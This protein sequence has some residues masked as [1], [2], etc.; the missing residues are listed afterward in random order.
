[1]GISTEQWRS[2]IGTF[3]L[4]KCKQTDQREPVTLI[5]E[6][7]ANINSHIPKGP[8]KLYMAIIIISTCMIL[9]PSYLTP[10]HTES[11]SKA[12]YQAPS[13]PSPSTALSILSSSLS[14]P[15]RLT[16]LLISGIESNPGPTPSP[17]DVIADLCVNAPSTEIRD[18]IRIY[19]WKQSN[20]INQ[21]ELKRKNHRATIEATL[22]Y[23]SPSVISKDYTVD[24]LICLIV[25]RINTLLPKTCQQCSESYSHSLADEPLL[26]CES[27]GQGA[28]TS[29]VLNTLQIPDEERNTI[30]PAD[31]LLKIN[32]LSLP[33]LQYICHDCTTKY[34]PDKSEGLKKSLRD[35]QGRTDSVSA[36]PDDHV[37]PSQLQSDAD[38]PDPDNHEDDD[39]ENDIVADDAAST[40]DD[41]PHTSVNDHARNTTT[42][43]HQGNTL[44][45]QVCRF[46][47]KGT[48][49]YGIA[50]RGCSRQH[51][52]ACKKLLQHGDRGPR[53][54]SAGSRCDKFHPLMCR[55]SLRKRECFN[56]DC[57]LVHI[58]GTKRI[59]PRNHDPV[60]NLM[61]V[62][63]PEQGYSS[64]GHQSNPSGNYNQNSD[65][66]HRP[67]T[68][69]SSYY[70]QNSQNTS[71]QHPPQYQSSFL[72][73]ALRTMRAEMQEI[74]NR[75]PDVRSP[76]QPMAQQQPQVNL[77][78]MLN[79][80]K[81]EIMAEMNTR[82]APYPPLRN[83]NPTTQPGEL[84]SAALHHGGGIPG[85]YQ[86]M[87]PG[88]LPH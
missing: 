28:H 61:D 44:V 16:L 62:N 70:S 39:D 27:C 67:Q 79:Q 82:L 48:C 9:S 34:L 69:N 73:E 35:K 87:A 22:N 56:Q 77:Q 86:M 29:C 46:Y 80:F 12:Q 30:N 50:G 42:Q 14:H 81:Q 21:N 1:M 88:S 40:T 3:S 74:R 4:G 24:G 68:Q 55:S 5:K 2:V 32:P 11:I 72:E 64:S 66:Q 25:S 78:H 23:L 51:P 49:R 8:W 60:P 53:G 10:S 43:H 15:C 57:K 58:V 85:S 83:P 19:R 20:K 45:Q 13:A 71:T 84:A 18:C 52:K 65:S 17:D 76:T 38:D 7:Q 6:D 37:P 75:I 54:C 59:K 41:Q 47:E 36:L 26:C 63:I 31:V 33:Q